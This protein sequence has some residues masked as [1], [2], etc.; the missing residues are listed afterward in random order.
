M[1]GDGCGCDECEE[2][3][4]EVVHIYLPFAD[5]AA[6]PTHPNDTLIAAVTDGLGHLIHGR[7]EGLLGKFYAS[8]AEV[9]VDVA[10]GD[11]FFSY[12]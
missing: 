9:G 11:H 5:I 10:D 1:D 6:V 2:E 8:F 4:A 12:D 3:A 7:L